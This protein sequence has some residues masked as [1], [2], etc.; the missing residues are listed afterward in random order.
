MYNDVVQIH[1]A[2]ERLLVLPHQRDPDGGWDCVL[3]FTLTK[4]TS[5]Q[6]KK[7]SRGTANGENPASLVRRHAGVV[8][9]FYSGR[10]ALADWF[11]IAAGVARQC[12]NDLD[13]S[14]ESRNVSKAVPQAVRKQIRWWNL[15]PNRP[16][17]SNG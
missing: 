7:E 3:V 1:D 14:R 4:P 11:P 17:D 12:S 15:L 8:R 13:A 2:V 6:T 9:I 5:C 10:M 16:A